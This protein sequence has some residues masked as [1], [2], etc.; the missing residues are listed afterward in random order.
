[1]VKKTSEKRIEE[2]NTIRDKL[3][4]L[5]LSSEIKGIEEFEKQLILFS[6]GFSS[7]GSIKLTGTQRRL[8]YRLSCQNHIVSSVSLKYDPHI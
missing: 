6:N 7:S 2:I 4:S 8:E 1:M 5:G 3:Q